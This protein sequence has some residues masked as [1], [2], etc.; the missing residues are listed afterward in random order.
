MTNWLCMDC[1]SNYHLS[2]SES[3]IRCSLCWMQRAEL[4]EQRNAAEARVVEAARA[5]RDLL[6]AVDALAKAEGK[7]K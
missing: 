6:K 1:G 7:L 3:S 4:L 2:K 5:Y